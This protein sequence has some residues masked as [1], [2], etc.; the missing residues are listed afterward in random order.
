MDRLDEID[1]VFAVN[2]VMAIGALAALRD[3]GIAVPDRIAL[4]GY[5]DIET[6]RDVSPALTTVRVPLEDAG[7]AAMALALGD[8]RGLVT[9]GVSVEV[10]ASTP[11]R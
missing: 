5:D 9:L 7:V 3:R 6:A 2:D 8:Q 10:R 1:L 11:P 4:A